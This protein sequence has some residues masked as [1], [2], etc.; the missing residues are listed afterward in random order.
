MKKKGIL[1]LLVMLFTITLKTEASSNYQYLPGGKNYLDPSNMT[2]G[3]DII[4]TVHAFK[5]LPSQPYVLSFPGENTLSN[6][7]VSV[8]GEQHGLYFD[9]FAA[10]IASC[11]ANL[12]STTCTF[13]TD[14]DE[15]AISL[16]I[17]AE[18]ASDY[19]AQYGLEG[20]QLEEGTTQTG[21]EAYIAPI[22]DVEEPSFVEQG[23]YIMSYQENLPLSTII[24]RHVQV[25]DEVDGDLSNQIVIE[26]DFYTPN[27]GVVGSHMVTLSASD[28]SGNKAYFDL[29]KM[30]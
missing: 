19:F 22:I 21:Y 7:K 17:Q 1:L 25:I 15:T 6:V 18:G 14:V 26:E 9:G 28:A 12:L 27:I 13:E 4:E 5:V 3:Y 8:A 10:D 30:K 24:E 23:T 29:L 2:S 11:T 16:R 20:F